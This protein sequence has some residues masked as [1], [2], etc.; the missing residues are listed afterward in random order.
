MFA[1]NSIQNNSG[2]EDYLYK[3]IFQSAISF[4]RIIPLVDWAACS[5]KWWLQLHCASLKAT[6]HLSKQ[7]RWLRF[8]FTGWP[9]LFPSKIKPIDIR[10]R[11]KSK[12]TEEHGKEQRGWRF[13]PNVFKIPESNTGIWAQ[14][15]RDSWADVL[16]WYQPFIWARLS[17][18]R[19]HQTTK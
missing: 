6:V 2:S 19:R 3:F 17:V 4:Q 14:V 10:A 16:V 1:F 13:S 8:K 15:K 11:T 9:Q 7:Q 5:K 18:M 12:R